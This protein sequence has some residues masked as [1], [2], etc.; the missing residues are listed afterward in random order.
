M[1][2]LGASGCGCEGALAGRELVMFVFGVSGS[3]IGVEEGV[4]ETEG[5]DSGNDALLKS[6]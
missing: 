3:I 5:G 1:G 6:S 4:A 2:A